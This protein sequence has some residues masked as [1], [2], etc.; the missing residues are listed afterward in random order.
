[1]SIDLGHR[2]LAAA[3]RPELRHELNALRG[4]WS[5]FVLLG[6]ALVVLG[7]IALGSVMRGRS[8]PR[9]IVDAF[10]KRGEFETTAPHAGRI[11]G[12]KI[13]RCG[14]GR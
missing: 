8:R 13:G 4:N 9:L 6:V 7:T 3:L 11:E 10:D 12:S 1:M 14:P 2:P 5:W